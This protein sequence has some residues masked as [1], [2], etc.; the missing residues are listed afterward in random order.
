MSSLS[1]QLVR[2]WA[3][4][5]VV[6]LLLRWRWEF[7]GWAAKTTSGVGS[8]GRFLEFASTHPLALFHSVFILIIFEISCQ[9][10]GAHHG[11]LSLPPLNLWSMVDILPLNHACPIS[12]S[13]LSKCAFGGMVLDNSSWVAF[14]SGGSVLNQAVGRVMIS[15]EDCAGNGRLINS[16]IGTCGLRIQEAVTASG[17]LRMLARASQT[18]KGMSL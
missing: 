3:S 10:V 2:S 7:Y 5:W 12:A 4:V 16:V 15:S 17:I 1:H 14:S 18:Y 13:I 8:P 11:N 9:Y 6:K